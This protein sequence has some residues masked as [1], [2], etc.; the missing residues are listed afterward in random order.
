M[1]VDLVDNNA[2][3]QQIIDK[4]R[5]EANKRNTGELGKQEFLNLLILQLKYQDPL[6]PV[7]D[8]EFIAQMAQFSAL[9]QMQNM[10]ASNTAMKGFSMIGKY[11]TAYMQDGTTGR[12]NKI[13]GHVE[14]VVMSGSKTF[15]VVAGKEIPIENIYN[16]ADGFNPLNSTL[17]AYTGLIGYLV[18]GATYDLATGEIVGISGEVVSL[19]KGM[20]EDYAI[21]NG[22]NVTIAG[23]NKNGSIIEDRAKT[24]EYLDSILAKADPADRRIEVYIT[25][26]NGKRVPIAALLRSYE[27]DKTFGTIK[28]VLDEVASPVTSVAAI[29]KPAAAPT[30]TQTQNPVEPA[31]SGENNENSAKGGEAASSQDDDN[32]SAGQT[33]NAGGEPTESQIPENIDMEG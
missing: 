30:P 25:D 29:K 7:E 13:E 32:D 18:N 17:S 10:N 14:S 15:V 27:I 4:G 8:K 20:Y 1:A 26:E 21:L 22:V 3:I 16:V 24:K 9:E 5:A 31:K 11:V 2:F 19:L 33:Q 23:I 12:N 6:K 28:A